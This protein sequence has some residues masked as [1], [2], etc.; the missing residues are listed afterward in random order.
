MYILNI[1]LANNRNTDMM[2]FK[3]YARLLMGSVRD[4]TISTP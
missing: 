1:A 3:L 2:L 4:V